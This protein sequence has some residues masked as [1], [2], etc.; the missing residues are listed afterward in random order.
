MHPLTVLV[1]VETIET[2]ETNEK[3][4][5]DETI[6]PG[7]AVETMERVRLLIRVN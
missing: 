1:K 6:G 4:A 5:T 3:V 7:S 2:I